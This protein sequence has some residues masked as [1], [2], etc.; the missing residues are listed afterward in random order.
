MADAEK[1]LGKATG[2]YDER[3]KAARSLGRSLKRLRKD[4]KV[5]PAEAAD[6]QARLDG[7]AASLE[8]LDG[9]RP[10]TGSVFVRLFLGQV[11]VRAATGKDRSKLRDEYNKFKDRTNMGERQ[12]A[13]WLAGRE[14]SAG[15][16]SG[17]LNSH[18]A[19]PALQ[20]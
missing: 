9:L 15:R 20:A 18:A 19:A 12:R 14:G 11:N 6:A 13:G 1:H 4:G 8:E 3:L 17:S 16:T 2:K 7:L 5:A 10:T